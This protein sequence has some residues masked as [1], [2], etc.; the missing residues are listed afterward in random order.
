MIPV[1]HSTWHSTSPAPT[2]K[3]TPNRTLIILHYLT[4]TLPVCR[5]ADKDMVVMG[6]RI[7]KGTPLIL[8]PYPM[9]VSPHN[10]VQPHKFWPDRWMLDTTPADDAK[11]SGSLRGVT[12]LLLPCIIHA[13]CCYRCLCT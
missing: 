6:Y 2:P 7:P 12:G 13:Y 9:H 1:N 3:P 11:H 4:V 10:Y 5:E 8:A